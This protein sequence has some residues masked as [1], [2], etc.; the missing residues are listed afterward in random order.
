VAFDAIND[1]LGAIRE[2][3]LQLARQHKEQWE[4]LESELD[5]ANARRNTTSSQMSAQDDADLRLQVQALRQ[6]FA[7]CTE[8]L[9]NYVQQHTSVSDI[10]L[11]ERAAAERLLFYLNNRSYQIS[12][13]KVTKQLDGLFRPAQA[14]VFIM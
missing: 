9:A 11:A 3:M 6:D 5:V 2:R 14:C 8:F 1:E 12:F 7:C 13:Y 4:A 10:S